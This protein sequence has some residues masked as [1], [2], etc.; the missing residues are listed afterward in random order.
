M[1]DQD[2]RT[3]RVPDRPL[4]GGNVVV[5]RVERVLDCN[6]LESGLFEIRNDF[7]PARPVRK[8]TMD[9]DCGLGFQLGSRSSQADRGHRGQEQ[10]EAH[11]AFVRFHSYVPSFGG[12]WSTATKWLSLSDCR[13][14]HRACCCNTSRTTADAESVALLTRHD[15]MPPGRRNRARC[16]RNR[17]WSRR[18][19]RHLCERGRAPDAVLQ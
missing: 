14:A 13:S 19:A 16:E 1:A 3:F 5:Q 8:R 12:D 4:G 9:K 10:A 17:Y 15:K 7:V 2:D 6:D 18:R 11:N